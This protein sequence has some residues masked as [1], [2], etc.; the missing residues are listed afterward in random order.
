MMI[1]HKRD[2]GLAI[3]LLLV[4]VA[5][6]DA[7]FDIAPPKYDEVGPAVLVK[8]TA[9][10]LALFSSI[11]LV[12]AAIR[13][14]KES[15]QPGANSAPPSQQGPW[16]VI[17]TVVFFSGYLVLMRIPQLGFLGATVI[18][19]LSASILYGRFQP[20]IVFRLFLRLLPFALIMAFG[21]R[22][23]FTQIFYIDL[24]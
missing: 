7:S 12:R 21:C 24:P 15:I 10:L 6:F 16:A 1:G 5:V 4:S 11:I 23:V 2:L 9:V 8:G 13:S 18:Y 17:G 19:L 14:R 20:K 22:F 3:A